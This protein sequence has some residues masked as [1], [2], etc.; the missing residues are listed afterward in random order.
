MYCNDAFRPKNDIVTINKRKWSHFSL[1]LT[2][3]PTLVIPVLEQLKGDLSLYVR[4]SV[5]NNL[6]DIAKDH[7]SVVLET[8][9][10]WKGVCPHTDWIIRQGC[11]TLI[12][13]ADP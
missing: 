11:R 13:K 6:N 12:R 10:R 8:V 2:C 9:R 1:V 5:A 7:P 4:K 3:D